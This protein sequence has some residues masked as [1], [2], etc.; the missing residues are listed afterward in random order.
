MTIEVPREI[1]EL[2]DNLV[3][4]GRYASPSEVITAALVAFDQQEQMA[5]YPKG[6][7]KAVYPDIAEMI[8]ESMAQARAGQLKDGEEFFKELEREEAEREASDG[9]KTA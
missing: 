1:E 5:E 4:S 7:I 3:K 6:A 2:I 9:R 8:A